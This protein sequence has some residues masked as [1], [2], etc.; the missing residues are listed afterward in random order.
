M[1]PLG[2]KGPQQLTPSLL[3][4]WLHEAYSF[5]D[6]AFVFFAITHHSHTY[7]CMRGPASLLV[8]QRTGSGLGDPET[9]SFAKILISRLQC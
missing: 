8:N 4:T 9:I 7:N 2:K 6:F 3:C 5:V 1:T